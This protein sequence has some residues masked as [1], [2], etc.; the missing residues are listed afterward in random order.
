MTPE[1][2]IGWQAL[3]RKTRGGQPRYADLAIETVLSQILWAAGIRE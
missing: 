1:A 3:R 2:L